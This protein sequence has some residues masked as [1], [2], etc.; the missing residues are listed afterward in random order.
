MRYQLDASY[1]RE[2]VLAK[3]QASVTAEYWRLRAPERL[4]RGAQG[5]FVI[6][7]CVVRVRPDGSRPESGCVR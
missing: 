2:T 4:R 3:E 6:P 7:D 5:E 1:R